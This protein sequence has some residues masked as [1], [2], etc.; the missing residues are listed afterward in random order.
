M[1]CIVVFLSLMAA[2]KKSSGLDHVW[3]VG[4]MILAVLVSIVGHQGGEL[5]YGEI[6]DKAIEQFKK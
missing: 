2:R 4:A 5:V 3:K 1:S 6:F